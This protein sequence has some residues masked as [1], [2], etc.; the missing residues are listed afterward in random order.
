MMQQQLCASDNFSLG[1]IRDSDEN[2]VYYVKM[3]LEYLI[4]ARFELHH[5]TLYMSLGLFVF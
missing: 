1:S 2:T 5:E 4:F 3:A